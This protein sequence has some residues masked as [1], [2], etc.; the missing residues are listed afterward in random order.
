MNFEDE[1]M[2]L[3]FQPIPNDKPNDTPKLIKDFNAKFYINR[4]N[5]DDEEDYQI[6]QIS[7]GKK[8]V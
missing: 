8:C 7:K 3:H 2:K 5:E 4:P 6:Y 1:L